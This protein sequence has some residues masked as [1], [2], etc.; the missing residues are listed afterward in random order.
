[1]LYVRDPRDRVEKAA[2]FL[3]IDGDPYPAVIDGRVTWILDGYTTS[4]AYPYSEPRD[5]GTTAQDSLTGA[6]TTALPNNQFNYIR[7]SVK[8]TVD[9]YDGTV[10]LY[11][12]DE[13]DPVLQ[14]YMKAFPDSVEQYED[15][16]EELKSHV[17]YPEDLFK[18]QR[19]ILTRYHVEDPGNFY[20]QN[21]R[22]QVPA[23]P[24]Q[25]TEEAQPPY[26]ILAQRPG[27]EEATFQLTSALN[28]FNR[29]NLSSFISA[30]SDPETY[31]QIQV[32]RLPGNTP[33]RGPRQV[34]QSFN[35][36]DD[37][38]RDLN[39][40]RGSDSQPL[41]GNLLTLPI[42]EDGLLYVQPLYVEGTGQNS[43]PLLR[44]VLVNYG[45]RVGYADTL[46]G[47]LDQ[48]FGAGAGEAAADGGATPPTDEPAAPEP[49]EPAEPTTPTVPPDG[50]QATLDQ[51]VAGIQS[52]LQ[53]LEDAQRSGDFA[54][55]G[56]ALED[57]QG[58]VTAY[59]Q[60]QQ[61]AGSTPGG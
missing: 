36:N 31:G 47:A 48:V 42:G 39:L 44:K 1:V 56:Q 43:F 41:F 11:E 27:D 59:Q 40:F 8:A 45:D 54:A 15:I 53:A 32:L 20:S 29:D 38:A 12:W 5:L 2:P 6:G 22:W 57:L 17:R 61:A 60:A 34:Q 24:T 10:K 3:E 13:K 55:Q 49:T 4:D 16:P 50:E 33:F 21:D 46:E 51:A 7:N 26:Y 19:D 28:A 14:T 52:A 58:A 9:A 30:S 35:T 18:L 37:V 25:D 23:D